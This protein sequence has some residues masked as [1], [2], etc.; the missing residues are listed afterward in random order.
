MRCAR[1]RRYLVKATATVT[2]A[3]RPEHFG[4]ICAEKLG[5]VPPRVMNPCAGSTGSRRR[6]DERQ[7]ELL[8]ATA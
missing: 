4:P 6:R 2:E 7:M 8:G 5:L 1:C 3:G